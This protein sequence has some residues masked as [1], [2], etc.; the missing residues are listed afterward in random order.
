MAAPTVTP[1]IPES[2]SRTP[3]EGYFTIE[4]DRGKSSLYLSQDAV[5]KVEYLRMSL[6]FPNTTPNPHSL[7]EPLDCSPDLFAAAFGIASENKNIKE[8][9]TP[10]QKQDPRIFEILHRSLAIFYPSKYLDI[11]KSLLGQ[12]SNMDLEDAYAIVNSPTNE[13]SYAIEL[14]RK[15]IKSSIYFASG[16]EDN[17]CSDPKKRAQIMHSPW[18]LFH[19]S[20]YVDDDNPLIRNEARKAHQTLQMYCEKITLALKKAGI[21]ISNKRL[22]EHII[23]PKNYLFSHYGIVLNTPI[24]TATSFCHIPILQQTCAT[25]QGLHKSLSKGFYFSFK[26]DLTPQ[27]LESEIR[28]KIYHA[29][30]LEEDPDFPDSPMLYDQSRD[31]YCMLTD[32][33]PDRLITLGPDENSIQQESTDI[34]ASDKVSISEDMGTNTTEAIDPDYNI[35][36]KNQKKFIYFPNSKS[37]QQW[38]EV[39][40]DPQDFKKYKAS[41]WA[42]HYASQHF[43]IEN[44]NIH[45]KIQLAALKAADVLNSYIEAITAALKTSGANMDEKILRHIT[46]PEDFIFSRFG[47]VP[48]ENAY[49][50]KYPFSFIPGAINTCTYEKGSHISNPTS[51]GYLLDDPDPEALK[52]EN[53]QRYYAYHK[54]KAP[55]F[56]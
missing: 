24:D 46:G 19:A 2:F 12:F 25:E 42:L 51:L 20:E 17:A 28:T 32:P 39:H 41:V 27:D 26:G 38:L 9:L 16:E 35:D 56:P 18:G 8:V 34:T 23:G 11:S 54:G 37:A 15:R 7:F 33:I 36:L 31:V 5:E 29:M 10:M 45:P 4:F 50:P 13:L 3:M 21:D 43:D 49:P 14:A 55:Y 40:P 48:R 1:Y 53:P 47:I 52:Q 44:T 22:M 6:D 30:G